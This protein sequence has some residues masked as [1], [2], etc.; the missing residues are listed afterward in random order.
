[1][2]QNRT[3]LVT[4]GSGVVGAWAVR[5]I[6]EA[7]DTPV[8]FTRGSTDVGKAILGD[9]AQQIEWITGDVCQPFDLIAALRRTK[10]VAIAHLAAAKPWQMEA[11]MVDRPDPALG[12]RSI[13]AGTVN[14]LDAARALDIPRVVYF[15]SKAAYGAFEGSHGFPDYLPVPETYLARPKDVYGI[16]KLAAESLAIYYRERL[17]L[18]VI[19]LRGASAFGPFKRGAG[20]SPPGLI[21]AALEGREVK[22][23]YGETTYRRYVD[24]LIYNRDL[25]RAVQL[26]TIVPKTRDALFN[27]GSGVGYSPEAVVEAIKAVDGLAVPSIAVVPDGDPSV[28]GGL[29]GGIAGGVF[30]VARARDQ[31]GFEAKFDL[32]SGLRDSLELIHSRQRVKA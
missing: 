20:V 12:V 17:G 29:L 26:A 13:V 1:M 31:L 9:L 16:T 21:A 19:A 28:T 2:G 11:G 14:V 32:I 27:I 18:D 5:A 8:V 22:A 30:D 10:P 24:E 6:A 4:G 15:S 23:T 3:I 7:G 25:G